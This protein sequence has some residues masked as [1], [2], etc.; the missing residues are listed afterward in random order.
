MT[1]EIPDAAFLGIQLPSY[2][3]GETT[4]EVPPEFRGF[5]IAAPK[6]LLASAGLR[7]PVSAV[8][9]FGA[10]SSALPRPL[11]DAVA[12]VVVE[13]NTN[14][15]WSGI[16]M[17]PNRMPMK[18]PA[19]DAPEDEG[20]EPAAQSGPDSPGDDIPDVEVGGVSSECAHVD[21]RELFGL[22]GTPG[23][24]EIHFTYGKYHSNSVRV[25]VEPVRVEN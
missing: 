21:L 25:V 24:Y 4:P 12:A 6:R 20:P 1:D 14:Q 15:C 7:L 22:P 3:F 17:D 19:A 16:L 2:L 9:R 8:A 5:R 13:V 23:I 11:W 10:E 18:P